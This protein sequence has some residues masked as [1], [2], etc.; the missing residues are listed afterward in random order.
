MKGQTLQRR[1]AT[2]LGL[3]LLLFALGAAVTVFQL[4]SGFSDDAYDEWLLDTARSIGLLVRPRDGLVL[5]DLAP[6]ALDAVVFDAHD[7]VLFRIDSPSQGLVAGHTHLP[8][9]QAHPGQDVIYRDVVIDGQPMRLVQLTRH[10]LLPDHPVTISVAETL[11][12]RDRLTSRLL[13]TVMAL[14]GLLALIALWIA[15]DV[16]RTGLR[17]LVALANALRARQRGDLDPIPD[18]GL[19]DELRVFTTAL[20]DLLTQLDEAVKLQRRFVTDAAHQLRTPLATLKVELA[21][22]ERETD[23]VRRQA[24]LQDLGH[25]IDRLA[26]LVHQ[27]LGLARAEP[28]ALTH[29]AF[30]PVPLAPLLRE[31]TTR[32]I[33]KALRADIDLGFEER[34]TATVRGDTLLLEEAVSNL[35]DNALCYAGPGAQVTVRLRHERKEEVCIEVEDNGP[36]VPASELPHLASRFHRCPGSPAGGSGLG[37]SI[38]DE[39]ARLHGGQLRIIPTEPHG[40]RACM[41]LPVH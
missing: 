26:R 27:L 36:G 12:K 10:D 19:T 31:V 20:N 3:V 15:G 35:I 32:F 22:A 17:P 28:G 23:P 40:L 5:G 13:G 24:A 25:A 18:A 11:H 8:A 16:I 37:L 9:A 2:R 4:A 1:L 33:P 41:T 7:R 14:I 30:Q 34:A 29:N 21:H 39:T 38:V 6:T